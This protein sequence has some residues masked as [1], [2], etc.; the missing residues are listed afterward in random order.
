MFHRLST[1]FFFLVLASLQGCVTSYHFDDTLNDPIARREIE[2]QLKSDEE[3]RYWNSVKEDHQPGG[4]C[5]I[6]VPDS[7]DKEDGIKKR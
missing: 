7:I 3:W 1:W 2:S 6:F 5:L 4:C